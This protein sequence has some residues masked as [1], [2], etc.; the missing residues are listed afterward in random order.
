MTTKT[1]QTV[2]F[3][4]GQVQCFND[5][6]VHRLR[7]SLAEPSHLK[8]Q[9]RRFKA[10]GHPARLAILGLLEKEPCCVCD[11]ANILELPLSTLSQH[12]KT[13][14]SVQLVR[15]EQQGKFVLYSLD[16]HGLEA[17]SVRS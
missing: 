16:A 1:A 17:L 7:A 13:L 6:K 4:G 10:L 2:C 8:Q 5:G 15:S 9:A 11:L 3:K 14:K 12:L